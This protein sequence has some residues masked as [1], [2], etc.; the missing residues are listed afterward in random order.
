MMILIYLLP[1]IWKKLDV[2]LE[3][4]LPLTILLSN[5]AS[6]ILDKSFYYFSKHLRTPTLS[7]HSESASQSSQV[8]GKSNHSGKN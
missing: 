4:F 3:F 1:S 7:T 8:A 6:S 5:S 2:T